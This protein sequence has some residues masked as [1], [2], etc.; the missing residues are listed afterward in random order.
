LVGSLLISKMYFQSQPASAPTTNEKTLKETDNPIENQ[1]SQGSQPK[2]NSQGNNVQTPATGNSSV[3]VSQVV[4]VKLEI[5]KGKCWVK[6]TSDE[7]VVFTGTLEGPFV[8]EFTAK[9][10]IRIVFGNAGVVKLY[11]DGQNIGKIGEM[12]EVVTKVFDRD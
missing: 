3:P 11:R 9:N 10:K 5:A 4:S 6:V 8:K 12:G 1:A 7:Q 2:D